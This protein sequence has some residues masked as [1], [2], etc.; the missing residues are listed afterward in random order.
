[1]DANGLVMCLTA[2]AVALQT[3][4]DATQGPSTHHV[5]ARNIAAKLY[6]T[7]YV[8]RMRQVLLKCRRSLVSCRARAGSGQSRGRTEMVFILVARP[9]PS[10]LAEHS[11]ARAWVHV[12]L[13]TGLLHSRTRCRRASCCTAR[14]NEAHPQHAAQGEPATPRPVGEDA[15]CVHYVASR[16]AKGFS[17]LQLPHHVP[18]M[19]LRRTIGAL[20]NQPAIAPVHT[21]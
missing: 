20:E 9:S 21:C 18:T 4:T 7:V 5:V 10:I 12:G 11:A 15:R 1:L 3:T 14:L 16:L 8:P 19:S 2:S 6:I 13:W 17:R